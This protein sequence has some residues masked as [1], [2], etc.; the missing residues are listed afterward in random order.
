MSLFV[1]NISRSVTA[2][3]LEKEFTSFGHCSINYKGSYS[4]A[5]FDNEKDAEEAMEHLQSKNMGGKRINIEWSRKSKRYDGD[6]KSRRSV[7]P[8]K[9]DGRCYN[10][11]LKGHYLK[12]CR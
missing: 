6:R 8:R 3:D 7:S 5:E 11:G 10:C 9:R 1:G 4:F 12:D 2:T